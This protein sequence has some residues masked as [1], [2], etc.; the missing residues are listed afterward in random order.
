MEKMGS[1]L[2]LNHKSQLLPSFMRHTPSQGRRKGVSHQ[3]GPEVL[4]Y[5]KEGG[6]AEERHIMGEV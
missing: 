5:K 6:R 4:S 2:T 1:E 3:D